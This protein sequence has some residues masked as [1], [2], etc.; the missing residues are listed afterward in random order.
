MITDQDAQRIASE[1]HSGQTSALYAFSSTGSI[2]GEQNEEFD[3]N[4]LTRE[5]LAILNDDTLP[6]GDVHDL[7]N[8]LAYIVHHGLRGPV[9]DWYER[10]VCAEETAR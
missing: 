1:W 6:F 4:L 5:C 10:V 2:L 3:Y 8:L 7:N 9:S